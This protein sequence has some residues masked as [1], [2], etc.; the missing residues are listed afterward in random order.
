M[1]GRSSGCP[2]ASPPAQ[3]ARFPPPQ[4]PPFLRAC[5]GAVQSRPCGLQMA[6][7]LCSSLLTQPMSGRGSSDWVPGSALLPGSPFLGNLYSSGGPGTK[8]EAG[9]CGLECPT[10]VGVGCQT[11]KLSR[12]RRWRVT[13]CSFRRAGWGGPLVGD[14]EQRA[15]EVRGVGV[16]GPGPATLEALCTPHVALCHRMLAQPRD[17]TS[18]QL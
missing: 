5:R 4:V 11:P 13:G 15:R 10:G 16:W 2:V 18:P 9:Q 17:P 1:H 8:R 6:F 12:A 3:T 7:P 14:L